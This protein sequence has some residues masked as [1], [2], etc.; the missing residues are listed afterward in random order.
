MTPDYLLTWRVHL[1]YS[2]GKTSICL[3]EIQFDRTSIQETN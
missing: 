3:H 1:C 2:L